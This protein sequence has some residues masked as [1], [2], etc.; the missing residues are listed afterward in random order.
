MENNSKIEFLKYYE[1]VH[2][3]LFKYCR[4]VSGNTEDA[5]DLIQDTI[6]NVIEKFDKIKD[7]SVFKSYIFSVASN[8]HKS[9]QRRNKFKA[10]FN[11]EEINQIIDFGQNQ[12]HYTEF[13]IVYEK[14]LSLPDKTAETLILFHISDLS[15]E[16]IQKI[17]GG[18][19]SGVKSRLQR[20]REKVLSLLK[21][22]E[23]L[24]IAMML[25]TF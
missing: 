6:L 25:L 9:K 23:Q 19:I 21:T 20:G 10:A 24:K 18:S 4:A 13:K 16:E 8:L 12:E 15:I 14:I 7:L 2:N 3:Q 1:P 22:K 11:E 17:Q 5:E